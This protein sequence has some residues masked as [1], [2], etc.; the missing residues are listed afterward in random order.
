VLFAGLLSILLEMH[1]F[2]RTSTKVEDAMRVTL[3][4]L[5]YVG[6]ILGDQ[7][8]AVERSLGTGAKSVVIKKIITMYECLMQFQNGML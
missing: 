4:M 5:T 8:R 2:C 1:L 6:V 7:Y 3:S